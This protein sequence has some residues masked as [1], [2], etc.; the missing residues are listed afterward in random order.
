MMNSDES[1]DLLERAVSPEGSEETKSIL[2]QGAH[3]EQ[4]CKL[5]KMD[6]RACKEKIFASGVKPIGKR[7][8]T[9]VYAIHEVAP[10]LVKPIFDVETAIK[11]MRPEDL[12][13]MLR[14]EF[15]AGQR[16]RQ[17]VLADQGNLWPTSKVIKEAGELFKIVKMSALLMLDAAERRTELSAKQKSIIQELT[18]GMLEDLMKRIETRFKVKPQSKSSNEQLQEGSDDTEL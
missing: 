16:S 2:Y 8:R 12:P 17:Q 14:K 18:G 10:Y 1:E 7:G 3:V 11:R 13:L 4:L 15:W 5:F 9:E 6:H